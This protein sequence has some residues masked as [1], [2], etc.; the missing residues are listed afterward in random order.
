M[1][2][3]FWTELPLVENRETKNITKYVSSL[4]PVIKGSGKY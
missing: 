3:Y 4:R 1:K 2:I